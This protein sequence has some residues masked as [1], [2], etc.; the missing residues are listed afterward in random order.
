MA[1]KRRK[2]PTYEELIRAFVKH[3][4]GR[5]LVVAERW[6]GGMHVPGQWWEATG[7]KWVKI[8][9]RKVNRLLRNSGWDSHTTT[10]GRKTMEYHPLSTLVHKSGPLPA[11]SVE[12]PPVATATP[13]TEEFIVR[14]AGRLIYNQKSKCWMAFAGSGWEYILDRE[15]DTLLCEISGDLNLVSLNKIRRELSQHIGFAVKEMS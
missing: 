3:Q 14:H 9:N 5:L 15:V 10:S 8:P 13:V 12:A 1:I 6:E 2:A 4:T 11:V 7:S